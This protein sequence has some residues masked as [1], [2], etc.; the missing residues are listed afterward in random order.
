MY[1]TLYF[2]TQ[3]FW[4]SGWLYP[5]RPFENIFMAMMKSTKTLII[6]WTGGPVLE[7]KRCLNEA[8]QP[9]FPLP[10]TG[11]ETVAISHLG[12]DASNFHE[13]D[14]VH[15]E[16]RIRII[17]GS[18]PSTKSR[19]YIQN[20]SAKTCTCL[21]HQFG[22]SRKHI[23]KQNVYCPTT[24]R[25]FL[26]HDGRQGMLCS[27]ITVCSKKNMLEKLLASFEY[28]EE[29]VCYE[30][31][32][33]KVTVFS[34]KPAFTEET[35]G[36]HQWLWIWGVLFQRSAYQVKQLKVMTR[37]SQFAYTWS[38]ALCQIDML[39]THDWTRRRITFGGFIHGQ[40][41]QHCAQV[42]IYH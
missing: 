24:L 3:L 33:V 14:Q 5:F 27:S 2:L 7:R 25:A 38:K 16:P 4:F 37:W 19:P 26:S 29:I 10:F 39:F 40:N 6:F 11:F 17:V 21:L 35:R 8:E 42:R 22:F 41:V 12:Y 34:S 32:V 20:A 13:I 36:V 28:S 18:Y 23:L 30:K 9:Q 15:L 1:W 31:R